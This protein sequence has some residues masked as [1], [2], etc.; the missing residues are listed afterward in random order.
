[1]GLAFGA[2]GF[3]A[4]ALVGAGLEGDCDGLSCADE[5]FLL[6]SAVGA[7]GAGVGVH[8]GN[9]SRGNVWL[10]TLTSVGTGMAGAAAG[11]D[12]DPGSAIVA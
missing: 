9:G 2:A 10:T 8:L 11:I 5:A 1:M 12:D 7:S 4:G 3:T 6:G